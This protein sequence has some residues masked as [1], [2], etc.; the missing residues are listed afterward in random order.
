MR[1]TAENGLSRSLS[2]CSALE[3]C[4]L[5]VLFS[6]QKKRYPPHSRAVFEP[7]SPSARVCT[8]Q[9]EYADVTTK[10]WRMDG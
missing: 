1:F 2:R 9:W 4:L 10:I 3:V 8:I 5:H 6:R 7:P